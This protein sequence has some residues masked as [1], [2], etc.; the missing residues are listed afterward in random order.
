[1]PAQVRQQVHARAVGEVQIVEQEG[2]GPLGGDLAHEAGHRPEEPLR[3]LA[4]AR[5]RQREVIRQQPNQ[6]RPAVGDLLAG[7]ADAMEEEIEVSLAKETLQRTVSELSEPERSVIRLRYGIEGGD[8]QALRETGRRL[9]L[10]AERV[11]QIESRA[12]KRLAALREI[13]ALRDAA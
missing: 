5:R 3:L 8:P 1:M 7:D 13:D 12:L 11:R 6:I 2:N 9:G 4:A 10:S